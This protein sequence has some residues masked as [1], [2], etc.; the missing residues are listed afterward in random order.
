METIEIGA[1]RL[2]GPAGPSQDEFAR[3][4]RPLA[5]PV[6]TEFCVRLTGITQSEVDGAAPFPAVLADFVAW[7]GPEPLT[8]C[9]WGAYDLRQL[10]ADCARHGGEFPAALERHVNLKQAFADLEHVP[11]CGMRA[12]LARYEIAIAGRHHRAL[13]DARN[14]AAL[15][16]RVLPRLAG[17]AGA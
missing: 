4:V 1:V 16:M 12:A 11:Q 8:W 14:I 7:A 2:A 9:S 3:F 13:D 6:L 10:Q 15:A 5:S 17:H